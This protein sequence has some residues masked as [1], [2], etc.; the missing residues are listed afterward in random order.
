MLGAADLRGDCPARDGWVQIKTE[1]G[2]L[3]ALAELRWT[4]G[5]PRIQPKRVLCEK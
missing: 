5:Q 1:S 3:L 4:A 2:E